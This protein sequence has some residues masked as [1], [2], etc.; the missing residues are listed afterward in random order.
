MPPLGVAVVVVGAAG[1]VDGMG[2]GGGGG[3]GGA[4]VLRPDHSRVWLRGVSLLRRI[5]SPV[6]PRRK[7]LGLERTH[8]L[9]S[10]ARVD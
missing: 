2:D 4:A 7:S 1:G 9:G 3:G 8:Q 6:C 10:S 5:H